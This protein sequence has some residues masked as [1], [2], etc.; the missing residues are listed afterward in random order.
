MPGASHRRRVVQ[1]R[2][3]G[4]QVAL[5]LAGPNWLCWSDARILPVLLSLTERVLHDVEQ[6]RTRVDVLLPNA[7]IEYESM[8]AGFLVPSW[9]EYFW[10][11]EGIDSLRLDELRRDVDSWQQLA[12]RLGTL[13]PASL[14]E[15]YKGVLDRLTPVL[16]LESETYGLGPKSPIE[17]VKRRDEAIADLESLFS[18]WLG[19]TR[20]NVVVPDT[21]AVLE[22]LDPTKYASAV[23]FPVAEVILCA[24][25]DER[26]RRAPAVRLRSNIRN[27]A[28][29]FRKR[30]KGWRNQGPLDRGVSVGGITIRTVS[31]VP[32]DSDFPPGSHPAHKDDRIIMSVL[33]LEVER[34]GQRFALLTCDTLM[35]A[36]AEAFGIH[37]EDL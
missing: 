36:R 13:I 16:K 6:L 5:G 22:E 32:R 31:T 15:R 2:T 30:Y 20:P 26:T 27:A 1:F 10:K 8:P 28:R 21:S 17:A 12:T 14:S 4:V 24:S 33:S 18:R 11:T 25:G 23:S 34:P 7:R 19:G 37:V 9:P 29:S 3:T 35:T